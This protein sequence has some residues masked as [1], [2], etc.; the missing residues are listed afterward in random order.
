MSSETESNSFSIPKAR[1][2]IAD[3]FVRRPVV[4]WRDLLVTMVITY[5]A[6]YVCV[7]APLFSIQQIICFFVVGFGAYGLGTFVHEIVHMQR[8]EMPG[9]RLFYEIFIGIPMF[10]PTSFVAAHLEHHST[11]HFGTGN[12]SCYLP[13]GNSRLR[14]IAYFCLQVIILPVVI[15]IRFVVITPISFLHPKLRKWV[16]ERASSYEL[17]FGYRRRIRKKAPRLYRDFIEIC[18]CLRGWALLG[19]VA[20]GFFPPTRILL[21]YCVAVL[22]LGLKHLHNIVAHHYR[23]I[24]EP[25]SRHGQLVDTINITGVPILTSL[26]LPFGLRY[27]ALHHLFPNIPY[28]NLAAAHHRLLAEFPPDSAYHKT[29]CPGMWSALRNLIRDALASGN[30]SGATGAEEWRTRRRDLL[31]A[32]DEENAESPRSAPT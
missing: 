25:M 2:I 7:S 20:I 4:Q 31:N 29:V 10:M 13:L 8:N 24:G 16:L 30:A 6:F 27:H 23:S 5:A 26:F 11:V 22:A 12:D 15:L 21:F 18:C 1:E 17:N 19:A 28:H 32:L 14:E 3:S 9:Y